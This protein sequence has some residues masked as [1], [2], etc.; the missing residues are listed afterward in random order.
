MD[1]SCVCHGK[2]TA[3]GALHGV[4]SVAA[5]AADVGAVGI[6]AVGSFT[7]W[8]TG[9]DVDAASATLPMLDVSS[10]ASSG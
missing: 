6:T 5:G 8:V 7:A 4:C 9:T 1:G 10:M 2:H 3:G